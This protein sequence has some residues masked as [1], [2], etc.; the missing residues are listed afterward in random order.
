MR[1]Y[2]RKHPEKNRARVKSWRTAN[3]GHPRTNV[4]ENQELLRQTKLASGCARCGYRDNVAALQLHHRDPATKIRGAL[5]AHTSRPRLEREI[6][7]CDV[8]C[9]NCHA[10]EH[11]ADS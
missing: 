6:A 1:E 4:S 2:H 9:A 10:V 11:Y 5:S 7:K 8:L 3:P